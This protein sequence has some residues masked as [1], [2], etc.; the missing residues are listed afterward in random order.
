MSDRFQFSQSKVRKWRTCR[1]QYHL[2][3][4]ERLEKKRKSRPLQFGTMVHDMLEAD[5]IGEDPF[6][7]LARYEKEQGKLFKAEIEEFGDIIADVGTI[8]TSYFDFYRDDKT[9]P[10]RYNKQYAEHWLEVPIGE[11]MQFVMKVDA[12]ARTPNKLRW[13]E[14]HKTFSR[15]PNDDDRW[16]NLQSCVYIKATELLG[17]KPFD[18]ILWNYVKSKPPKVPQI[19]KSGDVSTRSIDTL[20]S[21]V[22]ALRDE[23]KLPQ[24]GNVADLIAHAER[25]MKSWF[26]RVFTPVR[27]HVVEEIYGDFIDTAQEMMEGH[28]KKCDRNIGMHCSWCDFEPICRATLT[29]G[30]ADFV[31]EKGYDIREKKEDKE[32]K[33]KGKGK[34]SRKGRSQAK[35]EAR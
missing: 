31:K 35:R 2:R 27:T 12:F 32:S 16:R 18:G 13:I 7:V 23:L 10:I 5:L 15:A 26:F 28:S 3:Y 21:V 17:M 29:G 30:D 11:E 14:E 1:L 25:N 8:M 24:G 4:V 19:L 20:P 34:P 33:P 9:R 6:E 22:I